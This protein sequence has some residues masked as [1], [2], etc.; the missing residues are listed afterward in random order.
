VIRSFGDAYNDGTPTVVAAFLGDKEIHVLDGKTGK[1]S[2]PWPKNMP[3]DVVDLLCTEDYTGDGFP[4]IVAGMELGNLTIINGRTAAFFRG[5]MQ[6]SRFSLVY[7]QYM[8]YYENGFTYTNKTLAVSIQN[9]TSTYY[10]IGIDATSAR[11]PVMKQYKV[12][13]TARNLLNIDDHVSNFTGDLLFSVGN[14]VYSLSGTSIV[15]PQL[16]Q[17]PSPSPLNLP[18][19]AIVTAVVVIAALVV[20]ALIMKKHGKRTRPTNKR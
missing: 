19:L 8:D 17:K 13:S 15:T 6:V 20:F 11:L 5:P 3:D 18:W 1:E 10:I 9:S 14:T 12:S 7:L 16:P 2:T 4:D